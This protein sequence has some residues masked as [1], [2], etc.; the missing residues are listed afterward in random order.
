MKSV[1]SIDK[2]IQSPDTPNIL[3]F[4]KTGS[5]K[6]Y[7]GNALLGSANPCDE[8]PFDCKT[9]SSSVTKAVSGFNG[10]LFGNR[11]QRKLNNKILS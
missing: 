7:F 8:K 4:G 9:S 6:S 1:K 3:M 10:L 5:G 2:T 11:F